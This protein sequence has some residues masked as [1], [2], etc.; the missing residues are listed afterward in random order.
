MAATVS[1][2]FEGQSI[3]MTATPHFFES[4]TVTRAAEAWKSCFRT[5][6]LKSHEGYFHEPASGSFAFTTGTPLPTLNGYASINEPFDEQILTNLLAHG[7]DIRFPWSVTVRSSA[8]SP[9]CARLVESLGLTARI[10]RPF[11]LRRIGKTDRL[12]DLRSITAVSTTRNPAVHTRTLA[13]GF[14]VPEAYFDKCCTEALFE[15]P[16]VTV[17][18]KQLN[19]DVVS[20]GL[21]IV[22]NGCTGIFNVATHGEH[23]RQGHA[24][25]LILRML[26]DAVENGS[27]VAFL[28]SSASAM[29]FYETLGF[30]TAEFWTVFLS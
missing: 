10:S 30:A 18:V 19:G 11:M 9:A 26:S 12:S 15:D 13:H 8:C 3:G 25:E 17:Y 6:A 4:E 24:K 16:S 28:H 5:L 29:P 21:S 22:A 7:Q 27:S 20:T 23:R 2:G 1:T 14:D